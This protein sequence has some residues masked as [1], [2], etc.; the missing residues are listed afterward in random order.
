MS[1][2]LLDNILEESGVPGIYSDTKDTGDVGDTGLE[3]GDE[4][5]ADLDDLIESGMRETLRNTITESAAPDETK[6]QH[7]TII[8]NADFDKDQMLTFMDETIHPILAFSDVLDEEIDITTATVVSLPLYELYLVLAAADNGMLTESEDEGAAYD[9]FT[10]SV[11]KDN[12]ENDVELNEE[13]LSEA[14]VEVFE[15]YG[16]AEDARE[17]MLNEAVELYDNTPDDVDVI[18]SIQEVAEA[19]ISYN[20]SMDENDVPALELAEAYLEE[21]FGKKKT[22][23]QRAKGYV[24]GKADV[25]S[26]YVKGKAEKVSKAAK[27]AKKAVGK[28]ARM[29]TGKQ[30]MREKISRGVRRALPTVTGGETRSEKAQRIAAEKMRA[31]KKTAG[32]VWGTKKGKAGAAA[33]GLA[34]LGTAAT[35]AYKKMKGSGKSDKAAAQ[36]AINAIKAQAS[37][38]TTDKCKASAQKQIAKWKARM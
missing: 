27:G 37:K 6:L 10:E 14:L 1:F 26:K 17:D 25:A 31:A 36:S 16:I 5:Y 38:C 3:E 12:M 32:K 29:L 23:M 22:R 28:Q 35:L 2:E 7:L 11:L 18:P 21:L 19:V 8:E 9:A 30:T 20:N 15:K 24:K 34:A 33:L 4:V 13:A